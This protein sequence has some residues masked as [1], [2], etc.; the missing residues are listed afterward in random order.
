MFAIVPIV[1]VIIPITVGVPAVTVLIPPATVSCVAILAGFVQIVPCFVGL[2]ALASMM[3]NGFMKTMI[4]PG[5][6]P[7][8]IIIGAQTRSAGENQKTRHN[9]AG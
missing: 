9:S 8:T 7:L 3:L 2:T 4:G 6:A 5:N 1:V